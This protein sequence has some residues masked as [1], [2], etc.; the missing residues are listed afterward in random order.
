MNSNI[1]ISKDGNKTDIIKYSS[2]IKSKRFIIIK[3]IIYFILLTSLLVNSTIGKAF[4]SPYKTNCFQDISFKW[5]S[6][7]NQYFNK[8]YTYFY[9]LLIFSSL[10]IDFLLLFLLIHWII[11]GKSWRVV[12]CFLIFYGF[13]GMI[14]V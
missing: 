10:L 7:I 8:N 3:S 14:Q 12:L 2:S 9:L 6:N 13:R 4:E 5:N 1:E 11:R